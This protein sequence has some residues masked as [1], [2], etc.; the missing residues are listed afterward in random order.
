MLHSPKKVD[1]KWVK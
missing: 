1:D